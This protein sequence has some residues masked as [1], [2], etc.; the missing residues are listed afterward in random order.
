VL[1]KSIVLEAFVDSAATRF[2]VRSEGRIAVAVGRLWTSTA[3]NYFGSSPNVAIPM[4]AVSSIYD[5]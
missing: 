3:Y 4:R 1:Q 5:R 2:G